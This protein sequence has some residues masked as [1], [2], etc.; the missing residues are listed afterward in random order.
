VGDILHSRVA[1]SVIPAFRAADMEVALVAPETLLPLEAG[2]WE[3]PILPSVDDALD[4]GA[5]TLYALR[6]QKERMTGARIPSVAEYAR[7]YGV[8]GRHLKRGVLVMHPGPVNRGVEISGD[9]VLSGSSLIPD[10]VAS[11]V[12]VR[13]AVLALA[14]GAVEEAAA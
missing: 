3:L 6:L 2:A 11:G 14:T 9:A 8:A 4:W 13:S 7:Y 12:A 1:R 10:Q 5:D